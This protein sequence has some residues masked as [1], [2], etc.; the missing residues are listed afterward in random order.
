MSIIATDLD[1]TLYLDQN[2]IPGVETSYKLL[3][4]NKFYIYH[5]TNN[6]SQS[7][8]AIGL[9][10]EKLLQT[11]IDLSSIITPLV[12]LQQYLQNK[13]YSVY[14]YGSDEIKQFISRFSNVVKSLEECDLVILGR[15]DDPNQDK[16]EK[17][18]AAIKSGISGATL[19]KDLTYPVSPTEFIPG[20][21]QIAKYI[22]SAANKTLDSFGK[23]GNLFAEYFQKKGIKINYVIGDRVDTDI[24]FGNNMNAK[25]ILVKSSIKNFMPSSLADQIFDDFNKFVSSVV[26]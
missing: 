3:L 13:T 10:L 6:S 26:K 15:L 12:V 1:G 9:K 22:E 4:S 24:I 21:G 16:L 17:I 20:N 2:L 19:N 11:E 23:E 5:T 14:V 18:A 7:I 25:S 8:E